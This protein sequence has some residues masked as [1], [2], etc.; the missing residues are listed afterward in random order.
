M[1]KE[2]KLNHKEI[3]RLSFEGFKPSEIAT[4]TN[5]KISTVY[6]ILRD[7]LCKSYMAGLS[8][9]ADKAV[10]NVRERLAEMNISAL[11]TI[12]H[13]LQ[14]SNIDTTPAAV[15]LGAANSVLDRNGYK[16]PEKHEHLH[17]HFT[18]EDLQALRERNENSNKITELN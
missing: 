10:I 8:D 18:A 13:M 3:A 17:G 7:S 11:D 15:R 4:R 5:N 2:L 9:R 14:K 6:A 1:L 12:N 16:A